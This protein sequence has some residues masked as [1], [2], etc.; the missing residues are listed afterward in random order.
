MAVVTTVPA[1]N[2]WDEICKGL[3]TSVL[4]WPHPVAQWSTVQCWNWPKR[5]ERWVRCR[6]VWNFARGLK[7][8]G[9]LCD[10]WNRS[11]DN[12]TVLGIAIFLTTA[13]PEMRYSIIIIISVKFN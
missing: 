3:L 1:P 7:F 9:D 8:K 11:D 6:H 10:T 5:I 4:L 13:I 2:L 12:N